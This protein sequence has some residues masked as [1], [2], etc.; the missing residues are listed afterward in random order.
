MPE[1]P[2]V[3]TTRR[4][5]AP[6]LEGRQIASLEVREPRLRWPIPETLPEH[7][8]GLWIGP[9]QRR[10]K[11][12]LMPLQA[13]PQEESREGLIWHLGM[14]GSL[15]LV[16]ADSDWKKHDHL[17]L[18]LQPQADASTPPLRL[19]YHDP[20]R[21][22]FLLQY[23]DDPLQHPRLLKLGPE[24]LSEDFSGELL[25]QRSRGRKQAVKSFIMDAAQ[26]V[27]VGNIYAT[28][29]LFQAGIDPRRAAGR[30]SRQRYQR[31]ADRIKELLAAAIAQG[32]TTLRD[33]VNGQGEP[34][35]F[36]QQL[37]AYGRAGQACPTCSQTLQEV[38]IGQRASVYCPQCQN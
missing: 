19:R 6:W 31:L 23:Q 7:L 38:K 35:Y 20:R 17:E 9:L 30:I 10:A 36:A 22:G 4:G 21:F 18:T 16:E 25:Y 2:E 8:R 12:L 14:S 11:Y 26:V 28:E 5:I 33:F 32:G 1:L 15:R 3:E 13:G 29:A 37:L 24:P 27:G 34:G